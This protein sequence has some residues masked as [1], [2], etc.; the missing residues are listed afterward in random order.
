M[1]HKRIKSCSS[2]LAM[3]N[4]SNLKDDLNIIY[5]LPIRLVTIQRLLEYTIADVTNRASSLKRG[6]GY[7]LHNLAMHMNIENEQVLS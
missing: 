7:A 1:T 2:S 3:E 5:F 4:A 6:W